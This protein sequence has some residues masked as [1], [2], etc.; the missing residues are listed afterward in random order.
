VRT[1]RDG[2]QPLTVIRA[3]PRPSKRTQGLPDTS[4][5][6]FDN[7]YTVCCQCGFRT[8]NNGDW[9][10]VC[11]LDNKRTVSRERAIACYRD[12]NFGRCF[13]N[14]VTVGCDNRNIRFT[15]SSSIADLLPTE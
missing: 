11:T 7:D 2:N 8:Q 4:D 13:P 10:N 5:G 1:D 9:G 15:S 12:E 14:G 3:V 6:S